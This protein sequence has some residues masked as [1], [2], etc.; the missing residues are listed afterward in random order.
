M[1]VWTYKCGHVRKQ[2]SI[3]YRHRGESNSCGLL[4]FLVGIG[5]DNNFVH[6]CM[7]A[8]IICSMLFHYTCTC[9]TNCTTTEIHNVSYIHVHKIGEGTLEKRS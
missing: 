7:V 1:Y 2:T 5:K 4:Y 3:H 6:A 9:N 8:H